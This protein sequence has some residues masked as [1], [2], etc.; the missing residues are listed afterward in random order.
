MKKFSWIAALIV[1]LT[2]VFTGCPEPKSKPRPKATK[3][4]V[5]EGAD[6]VL[7]HCGN[8]GVAAHVDGNKFILNDQGDLDNVGF[9]YDFPAEVVGIGYGAIKVEMEVVSISSPNFIGLMTFSGSD[10]KGPV[11]VINK[12][13]GKQKTGQYDNEFKL[14]VACEKGAAGDEKEGGDGF[15]DGSSAAG[16][17]NEESFP[18][19]KFTDRI[20]WQVNKYAGNITTDGWDQK[21]TYTIAVTKITFVAGTVAD[22]PVDV[23]AIPGVTPPASGV[24]PVT[25]ITETAQ[26]T[27]TVAWKDADDAAVGATFADGVVYTATITLA[28]KEGFTFEGVAA[29][30][31]TVEGTSSPAT[32]PANSGVVTAVFPAAQAPATALT[33]KLGDAAK[34]VAIP[35]AEKG[36]VALHNDGNGYTY[37]YAQ[38]GEGINYENGYATFSVDFGTGKTIAEYESVTFTYK[39]LGG[40]VG[41]K[42]IWLYAKNSAFTGHQPTSGATV[43]APQYSD[44]GLTAREVTI[45][46][47]NASTI[48]GQTVHFII[49]V[50]GNVATS[51][52]PTSYEVSNIKFN[53]KQPDV[54]VN[55]KAIPLS[56]PVAGGTPASTIDTAQYTGA[57]VW[58][59]TIA[60]GGSFTTSTAY[61]AAITL[62]AKYGFT[63]DGITATDFFTLA[64]AT[65]ITYA[66][67]T[68]TVTVVFP[69]TEATALT[70]LNI[71]FAAVSDVKTVGGTAALE[72]TTGYTFTRSAGYGGGFASFKVPLPAGVKLSEYTSVTFT[73]QGVSGDIDSKQLVLL[74]WDDTFTASS[75]GS[76]PPGTVATG[77]THIATAT[78]SVTGTTAASQ[79]FTLT[80]ASAFDEADEVWLCFYTH[81]G[82]NSGN[83]AAIKISNIVLHP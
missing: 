10:F 43:G 7:K 64:G 23:K 83:E 54:A 63:L 45:S 49:A 75:V 42:P 30:F 19:R 40:D 61:T 20:A 82:A 38:T 48:T 25:A 4:F 73:Y 15:L 77:V 68:K 71:T 28:A 60:A 8:A 6:I 57:I 78:I 50:F 1:A 56:H 11:K 16:V 41:W 65:S 26:F 17:K 51:E 9:Y 39:G 27:G 81:A 46:L 32:N 29:N 76:N 13:T 53:T 44:N 52:V 79:S 34:Q 70:P 74:A 31:F 80:G 72:G 67:A 62:T 22:S 21:A 58:S 14:G 66:S 2:F 33:V 35:T 55:I 5:V 59:P 3:D 47:A 36:T 12:A 37:T 24:A 69:Q 18:F